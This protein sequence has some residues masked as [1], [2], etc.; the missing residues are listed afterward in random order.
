MKILHISTSDIS[1]GAARAA[2]RL[3]RSLLEKNIDSQMLVQNKLSDDWTVLADTSIYGKAIAKIKPVLSGL[4]AKI[5]PNDQTKTLLSPN[6]LPSGKLIRKIRQINP[7]IVHLHWVGGGMLKIEDIAKI[8]Q[9]I[10]WTLHDMW[11]F[12]NDYHYDSEYDI[13]PT[14]NNSEEKSK[15]L[16]YFLLR[17]LRRKRATYKKIKERLTV[18]PVSQ[19]LADCARQSKLF[20]AENIISLPN[21]LNTEIFSP[22]NKTAA[23][24]LLHLPKDK[25]L[26]AFGAISATSDPRKGFLKLRDALEFVSSDY[27]LVIFGSTKPQSPEK[28]K[29]KVHYLGYLND[30]VSL[31]LL[32]SAADVMV[33]PSILEAFGQTASESLSCGTPV[34]AFGA[35][36]LL[37]IV[38]H[39]KTGY[40]VCPYSIKDL[41]KGIEWVLRNDDYNRLRQCARKK[42]LKFFSDDKVSSEYLKLYESR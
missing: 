5:F 19:W 17:Q 23:R 7:D 26:I 8:K 16:S 9:P 33:V 29:Q 28:F 27:E 24:E 30:D 38:E 11:A 34:V 40:L 39:K 42:A 3:H 13:N 31:R 36:G 21:P 4:P 41:A 15:I 35:T 37:D 1:G 6:W 25:K 18:V 14:Q 32:Y 22:F 12:T 10:V 20:K 2:Y